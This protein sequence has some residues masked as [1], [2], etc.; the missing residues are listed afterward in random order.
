MAQL[1]RRTLLTGS[2]TGSF[3]YLVGCTDDDP[4]APSGPASSTATGASEEAAESPS[5]SPGADNHSVTLSSPGAPKVLALDDTSSILLS[6]ALFDQA[7]AVVVVSTAAPAPEPTTPE[8]VPASTPPSPTVEPSV[9]PSVAPSASPSV[10]PTGDLAV[11]AEVA[12]ALGVPLFRPSVP[13]LAAEL[14]RLGTRT[15][16]AYPAGN[17]DVG[18]REV[19]EGPA[20]AAE[21]P[22]LPGLPRTPE[23]ATTTVLTDTATLPEDVLATLA[24]AGITPVLASSGHPGE[25]AETVAQVKATD[26]V[27][28]LGTAFVDDARLGSRL[29]VAR[30]AAEL[31]GGGVTPFPGRRMIAL[32][33][34][35]GAPVLGMMGE[36]SPE[37]SVTRLKALVAE[38]QAVMPEENFVGAFEI[39]TTIASSSAGSD[40][41][42]SILSSFERVLPFIEA[43]E[44]NDVYVVLDLQP[45]RSTFLEQAKRYEELLKRPWV[46][47]ALDPEW[48]L[49]KPGDRHM[50]KIGQVPIEEVN[51]VGAWLAQLVRDNNLPP[52][53]LTL[54]QFQPRMIINR[55][56][57]DTSHDEIQYMVHVDGLGSQGAKQ[58]TWRAILKDLPAGVYTGWKNFEDEDLP[59]LTPA[60]TLEQVSPLPDFVSYQ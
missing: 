10:A 48:R 42:Y 1:S 27:L 46:G 34:H 54:H 43:A 22:E 30:T 35:P 2:A 51:E 3:L 29:E 15:V 17:L 19:I 14:D 56:L 20:S 9:E 49:L 36:Q 6:Q 13:G 23:K 59:M 11:A 31:P 38:Y 44:A 5:A 37:E 47:L 33:G 39:I 41:N 55:E 7:T 32:Y 26:S 24:A 50:V 8:S 21:L 58:G 28:A 45:G 52:K 40:G 57:L 25:T 53:V 12:K 60:Q 18:D 4:A 16:I